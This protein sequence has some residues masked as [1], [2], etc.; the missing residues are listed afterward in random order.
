M[1]AAPV[2]DLR[3]D[4][5]TRPTPEMRRAMAEAE[6]GDAVIDVDPTVDRLEKRTAELLGKEAAVFVPSGSMANQVALRTHCPAGTEFLCEADCHIYHY[7]QG[8]YASLSGLIP[9]LIA[10]D[11]GTIRPEQLV[12]QVHASDEHHPRTGLLCIEN[13]HNRW[14]GRVQ[15]QDDVV[16]SCQWA[17][18]HRLATHLDGARLWNAAV[19]SGTTV[20][21]LAAPFDSVSVCFSKGLGAPV[22]SA[23]AGSADFIREARRGRKL[24]GGAMRQAG[25]IAAGALHALQHHRDRLEQD[26]Q[27]AQQLGAAAASCDGLSIVGGRVETNMVMIHVD[28]PEPIGKSTE[29]RDGGG[30]TPAAELVGLLRERGVWCFDTGPATVRLVTHLDVTA[31]Q[32]SAACEAIKQSAECLLTQGAK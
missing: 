28:R 19:A 4:T 31:A 14:G 18:R 26:H 23:I 5:V 25:I 21:Q 13:T 1:Q 27:A 29:Q 2:I 7:E 20:E 17:R 32:V 15:R 22:G 9:R 24:F 6:V 3:S 11:D 16:A 8:A 30:G 10:T 12:G